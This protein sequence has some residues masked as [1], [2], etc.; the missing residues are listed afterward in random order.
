ML[1]SAMRRD[2]AGNPLFVAQLLRHLTETGA[3]VDRGG[4][5]RLDAVQGGLGVPDD[6][7]ELVGRR[8]AALGDETVS[9]LRIGAAIGRGFG[10]ELVAAVEG[11]PAESILDALEVGTAA[12]LVEE[13]AGGRH[14]FVHALVRDAI[15]EQTGAARRA[16][17][18][19]RVAD[20]LEAAD[21]DP[22]AGLRG[23]GRPLRT[24][25]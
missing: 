25:D 6:V 20:A 18:H 4:E 14:A 7:K 24:R 12:G 3:V 16:L 22:A 13:G 2:T 5:L 21:G 17:L 11:L 10:D 1:G 15:Y 19:R 9:A 8:L 23:R